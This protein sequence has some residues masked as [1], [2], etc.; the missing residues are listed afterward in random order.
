MKFFE[1]CVEVLVPKFGNPVISL[2]HLC[3]RL[4]AGFRTNILFTESVQD[5]LVLVRSEIF[6]FFLALVLYD[7]FQM[8]LMTETFQ[9]VIDI[10]NLL[11][12]YFVFNINMDVG[13]LSREGVF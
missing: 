9:F 6:K 2:T 10:S 3:V 4:N 11:S 1:I 13:T 8:M 5:F 12:T 7:I